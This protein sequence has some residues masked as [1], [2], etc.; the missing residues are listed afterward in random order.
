MIVGALLSALTVQA[1]AQDAR[2]II[3]RASMMA[4]DRIRS[5]ENYTIVQDLHG[6]DAKVYLEKIDKDG[7]P[8]FV[9]IPPH[10]VMKRAMEERGDGNSPG[11][12]DPAG[13]QQQVLNKAFG[14]AFTSVLDQGEDEP[15]VIADP[16]VIETLASRVR[17]I[18]EAEVDG[19]Q[20]FELTIDRVADIPEFNDQEEGG[21]FT[22]SS[23]VMY[24]DDSRYVTRLV[25]LQ[26]EFEMN[27]TRM[28]ITVE[29]RYLDYREVDGMYHPFRTEM[30]TTGLAQTI[31]DKDR[32]EMAK[33]QKEMEKA[34]E[35]MAQLP[36]AQRQQFETMM[37]DKMK[38]MED[39]MAA[40]E[41][42]EMEMVITIKELLVNA[43]PPPEWLPPED[44][45]QQT[46]T[47]TRE[48]QP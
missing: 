21:S 44:M 41:R 38:E 12:Q 9:A 11:L 15:V 40:L 10:V 30:R 31:S 19:Y 37:G 26:G 5:V 27:G 39:M 28:P 32:K 16:L 14:K 17:L 33:A 48:I 2:G 20:T 24:V 42:G 7:R 47:T 23:V 1:A 29:T 6:A 13:Y 43:G 3:D 22:P 36:A 4:A 45:A 35:Q 8:V 34:K 46:D 18:G 25:K